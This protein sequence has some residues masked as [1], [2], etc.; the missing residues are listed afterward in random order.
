MISLDRTISG[1][2]DW[3]YAQIRGL[4]LR[5]LYHIAGYY[6]P[7]K[8]HNELLAN[9]QR[10]FFEQNSFS[11]LVREK[12]ISYC[13]ILGLD[14]GSAELFFWLYLIC[15]MEESIKLSMPYFPLW[16]GKLLVLELLVKKRHNLKFIIQ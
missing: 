6:Y 12:I 3:E 14:I 1:V 13:N 15:P 10:T 16:E 7:A 8:G 9:F 4:P 11:S 5:D 2:I